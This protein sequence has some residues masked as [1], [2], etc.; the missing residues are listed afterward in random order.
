MVHSRAAVAVVVAPGDGPNRYPGDAISDGFNHFAFR[1]HL[2]TAPI[3][4]NVT[5]PGTH[6]SGTSPLAALDHPRATC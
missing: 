2:L 6:R 5:E 1:T 3:G 4:G